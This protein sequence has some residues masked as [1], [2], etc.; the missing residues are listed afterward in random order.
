MT[1]HLEYFGMSMVYFMT[2]KLPD[3]SGTM[4]AFSEHEFSE[5]RPAEEPSVEW[6]MKLES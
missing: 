4:A 5:R 6:E 3:M 2:K 1:S